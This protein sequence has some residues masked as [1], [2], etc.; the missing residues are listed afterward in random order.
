VHTVIVNMR[1]ALNEQYERGRWAK[2]G[3]NISCILVLWNTGCCRNSKVFCC[4]KQ[5]IY[6]T[7]SKSWEKDTVITILDTLVMYVN[8]VF[9]KLSFMV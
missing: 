9:F 3:T 1:E 8:L 4:T 2:I 5:M 6:L 7:I